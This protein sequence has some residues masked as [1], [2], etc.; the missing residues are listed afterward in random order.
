M[1]GENHKGMF[2]SLFHYSNI[3][4]SF[5]KPIFFPSGLDPGYDALGKLDLCGFDFP[6]KRYRCIEDD[7]RGDEFVVIRAEGWIEWG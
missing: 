3:P 6:F 2:F 1:M 7:T 4:E 5:F